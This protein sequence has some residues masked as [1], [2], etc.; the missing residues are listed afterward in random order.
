[1]SFTELAMRIAFIVGYACVI[2]GFVIAMLAYK[3][4]CGQEMRVAR[5]FFLIGFALI[6]PRAVSLWISLRG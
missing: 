5:I 2:I 3:H 4:D 6:A 1:M